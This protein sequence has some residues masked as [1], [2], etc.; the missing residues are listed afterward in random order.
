MVMLSRKLIM[1]MSVGKVMSAKIREIGSALLPLLLLLVSL[2]CN[3][4]MPFLN[5]IA[6]KA[7]PIRSIGT[8]RFIPT[9]SL[10][11]PLAVGNQWV[12][13]DNGYVEFSDVAWEQYDTLTV[14]GGQTDSDGVWWDL[15]FDVGFLDGWD[16]IVHYK[17]RQKGDSI[18][19]GFFSEPPPFSS[20]AGSGIHRRSSSRNLNE[21]SATTSLQ[22][23]PIPIKSIASCQSLYGTKYVKLLLGTVVTPAQEFDS[24]G[25]FWYNR[26]SAF[27]AQHLEDVVFTNEI[28]R[29]GIGIVG[30]DYRWYYYVGTT[31]L[32]SY[33][34]NQ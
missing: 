4:A 18:Y 9:K 14:V 27:A 29:P 24:C 3:E 23:V 31:R 2:S 19:G 26:D 32:L 34:L 15:E 30:F 6:P 21:A 22:Y 25:I 13:D 12:Y 20:S 5:D 16:G 17:L 10:D 28:L 11:F 7:N 1:Q 33:H 8:P